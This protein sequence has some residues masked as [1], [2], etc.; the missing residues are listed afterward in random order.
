[1]NRGMHDN[2]TFTGR[3]RRRTSHP[4]VRFSDALAR[5]LITLGGIGT[6]VAVLGVGVFL[7]V[8]AVP[9]FWSPVSSS[10]GPTASTEGEPL[11]IGSDESGDVAWV[12]GP[13]GIRGLGVASGKS[14]I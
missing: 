5:G 3:S 8:V 4:W 12:L 1:M 6:I 10:V 7:L 9:L 14:L 11:A 2:G 13:K